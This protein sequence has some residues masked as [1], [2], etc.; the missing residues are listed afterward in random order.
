VRTATDEPTAKRRGE[1]RDAVQLR[2]A[3]RIGRPRVSRRRMVDQHAAQI[4][5]L[6]M[7]ERINTGQ[8]PVIVG[9]LV[10]MKQIRLVQNRHAHG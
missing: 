3:R 10:R 6:R 1:P 7:G 5:A 2:D 9:G 4:E 8:I